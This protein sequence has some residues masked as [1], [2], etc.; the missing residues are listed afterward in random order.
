M[1]EPYPKPIVHYVADHLPDCMSLWASLWDRANEDATL[2]LT[3]DEIKDEMCCSPTIV[4]N[5]LRK[6]AKSGLVDFFEL[7]NAVIR[8]ELVSDSFFGGE[9]FDE[10]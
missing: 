2:M 3:K 9:L 4:I 8:V 5:R 7:N 1:K 10:L 6:L